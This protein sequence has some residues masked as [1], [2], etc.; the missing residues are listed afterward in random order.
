MKQLII[1]FIILISIDSKAQYPGAYYGFELY[2]ADGMRVDSL[3]R[4]YKLYIDSAGEGPVSIGICEDNKLWRLYKGDKNLYVASD[5]VVERS[6][7][8]GKVEKMRLK[9]PSPLTGGKE[10]YYANLYIG[11]IE[12]APGTYKIR[13]PKTSSEWDALKEKVYCPDDYS[14]NKY[15]DISGYQKIE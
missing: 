15:F 13:F 5:M 4:E 12:F 6:L 3:S 11:V 10:K 2:G 9:F 7:N 14:L 8:G 1:I